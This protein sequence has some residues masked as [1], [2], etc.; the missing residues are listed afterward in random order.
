MLA[1]GQAH[2]YP[3]L[4]RTIEWDTAAGQAIL[5]EASG[6]VLEF[7]SRRPLTYNKESLEN[8]PFLATGRIRTIKKV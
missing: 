7:Y 6:Q 3:R 4:G 8:P 2:L 1:E 5:E